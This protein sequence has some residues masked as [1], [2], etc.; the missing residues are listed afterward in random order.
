MTSSSNPVQTTT[1]WIQIIY[2]TCCQTIKH[3][4]IHIFHTL[5]P[6][7]YGFVQANPSNTNSRHAPWKARIPH[8]SLSTV[9]CSTPHAN[10]R[11]QGTL[12]RFKGHPKHHWNVFLKNC[13]FYANRNVVEHHFVAV[14][15]S[16]LEAQVLLEPQIFSLL[17]CS[18]FLSDA[19]SPIITQCLC[20]SS[21]IYY[22]CPR[23]AWCFGIDVTPNGISLFSHA[24]EKRIRSLESWF[25]F[26]ICALWSV[27]LVYVRMEK[28]GEVYVKTLWVFRASC[29]LWRGCNMLWI[30]Q[31]TC[32]WSNNI[33][34][35]K[36]CLDF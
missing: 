35:K 32:C 26:A 24:P 2:S 4:I 1:I 3:F 28:L 23:D 36:L 33:K 31:I 8:S 18:T 5:F 21:R 29:F 12:L 15:P 20:R 30:I 16:V 9:C 27:V 13:Q 11:N 7:L 19:R 34:I 6:R 25:C 22:Y 17:S 14:L 10:R